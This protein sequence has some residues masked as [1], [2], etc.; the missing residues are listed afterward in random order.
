VTVQR[1]EDIAPN[2]IENMQ[3]WFLWGSR[4]VDEATATTFLPP[5]E[6]LAFTGSAPCT[7]FR[8]I[9]LFRWMTN[10]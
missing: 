4:P 10:E 7:F 5:E 1:N 8:R 3:T 9:G 6:E 2:R